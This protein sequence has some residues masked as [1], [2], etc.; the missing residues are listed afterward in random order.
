V[1]VGARL[2]VCV[3]TIQT[4]NNRHEGR[5]EGCWLRRHGIN[6]RAAT[7]TATGSHFHPFER[8]AWRTRELCHTR[9]ASTSTTV[10]HIHP[11][12]QWGVNTSTQ[13]ARAGAHNNSTHADERAGRRGQHRRRARAGCLHSQGRRQGEA[14]L[15][16]AGPWWCAAGGAIQA[17]V[18]V[19]PALRAAQQ[20]S[21]TTRSAHNGTSA[22]SSTAWT[23]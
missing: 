2:F 1:R 19:S 11:L 4:C 20:H 17:P 14:W 13:R 23:V 10:R 22:A 5:P 18:L 3:C 16:L 12:A 8:D 15:L 21:L 6:R 9:G 7:P